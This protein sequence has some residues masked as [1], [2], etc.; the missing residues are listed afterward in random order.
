MPMPDPTEVRTALSSFGQIVDNFNQSEEGRGFPSNRD[1]SDG[2][3]EGVVLDW[4]RR[5]LQ[6]GRPSF[7][8]GLIADT[9][10]DHD[11]LQKKQS[12]AARQ[13]SA[14]LNWVPTKEHWQAR[15]PAK[16][17]EAERA[18]GARQ[19]AILSDLDTLED[20][21][22]AKLNARHNGNITLTARQLEL[23]NRFYSR[24]INATQSADTIEKLY[25]AIPKKRESL[26]E[27]GRITPA[28]NKQIELKVHNNLRQN[29]WNNFAANED[30]GS[31]KKK[32]F[33]SISLLFSSVTIPNQTL[34]G[35]VRILVGRE[36]QFRNG[37][38][39]KMCIG[40]L[41]GKEDFFHAIGCHVTSEGRFRLLDPNYGIFEYTQWK[42]GVVKA[43]AYLYKNAY[44]WTHGSSTP[45]P[46]SNFKVQL[47]TFAR[48]V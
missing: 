17:R 28:I 23:I 5:V 25:Y 47:D 21:L 48:K 39:V 12:Q 6:G 46:I 15:T 37:T 16:L 18:W 45:T 41:R 26:I 35:V 10:P 32:K 31:T 2:Y 4:L 38:G 11:F 9:N 19:D 40:G 33:S 24:N 20:G 29:A 30:M 14:F 44:G 42:T 8:P 1:L 36:G 22:L 13:A 27:A 7:G 34:E 3:C 43:V